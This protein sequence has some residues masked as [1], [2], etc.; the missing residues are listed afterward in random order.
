MNHN[1]NRQLT[2][3]AQKLRREMTKEEKLIVSAYTGYLMC[4]IGDLHEY[5][6]K[7]LGRPVWTHELGCKEVIDE[8]KAK[9]KEDFL[10]L[11]RE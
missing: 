10:Q 1:A 5:I 11:C 6:E 7:L 4:N 8:I 9:C 2:P 3:L